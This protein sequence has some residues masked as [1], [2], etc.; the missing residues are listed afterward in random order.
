MDF[1]RPLF[2]IYNEV[3]LEDIPDVSQVLHLIS[4]MDR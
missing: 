1:Y 4:S 2:P 3:A